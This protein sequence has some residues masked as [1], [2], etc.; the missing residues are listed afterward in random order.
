MSICYSLCN[1]CCPTFHGSIIKSTNSKMNWLM[2]LL[3]IDLA[4]PT[5]N[6]YPNSHITFTWSSG[7]VL[8]KSSIWHIFD[9]KQN[10]YGWMPFLMPTPINSTGKLSVFF[11]RHHLSNHKISKIWYQTNQNQNSDTAEEIYHPLVS[12]WMNLL[13]KAGARHVGSSTGVEWPE[14]ED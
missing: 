12:P 4:R 1:L 13:S 8:S 14:Q 7:N 10:F 6:L 9:L 2:W 5:S 3:D 11:H